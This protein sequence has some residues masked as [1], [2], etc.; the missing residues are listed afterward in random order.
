ML[1]TLWLYVDSIFAC[2]GNLASRCTNYVKSL[3]TSTGATTLTT[4]TATRDHIVFFMCMYMLFSGAPN[5]IECVLFH[6]TTG[7]F[8]MMTCS[9]E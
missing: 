2:E 9:D 4:P 7:I 3:T 8:V 6:L 1:E 5:S